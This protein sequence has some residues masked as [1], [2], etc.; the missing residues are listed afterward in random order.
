M[1]RRRLR[2]NSQMVIKI[3]KTKVTIELVRL[4]GLRKT[5]LVRRYLRT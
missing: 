5:N 1:R 3:L 4:L 2:G